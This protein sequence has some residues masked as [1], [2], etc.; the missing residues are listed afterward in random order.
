MSSFPPGIATQSA[1]LHPWVKG[2]EDFGKVKACCTVVP[3]NEMDVGIATASI[4]LLVYF[5]VFSRLL[6]F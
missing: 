1:S 3:E 5:V 4:K 2:A 6:P